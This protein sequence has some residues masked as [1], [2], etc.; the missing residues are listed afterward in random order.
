M[1]SCY[2]CLEDVDGQI[3]PVG[4]HFECQCILKLHEDCYA[5][6]LAT[7]G[8]AFDC[9][10]CHKTVSHE[11]LTEQIAEL[12]YFKNMAEIEERKRAQNSLPPNDYILILGFMGSLFTFINL[13]A[14]YFAIVFT[15]FIYLLNRRAE[16]VV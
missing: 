12:I 14:V 10:I 1:T 3:D 15:G 16:I 7:K 13:P 11:E 4:R 9:P 6:W 8:V 2:I 5:K